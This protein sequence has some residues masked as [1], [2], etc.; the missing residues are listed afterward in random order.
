MPNRDDPHLDFIKQA[1]LYLHSD[2]R[3]LGIH[4]KELIIS[5]NPLPNTQFTVLYKPFS[6][7]FN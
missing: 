1:R 4:S 5:Q 7:R 6:G 2:I 3:Y